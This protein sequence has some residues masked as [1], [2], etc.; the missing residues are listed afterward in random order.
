[1]QGNRSAQLYDLAT[2]IGERNNLAG[3]RPGVLIELKNALAEW[4][5]NVDR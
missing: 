1:M 5:L 4:E 3:T 2:D